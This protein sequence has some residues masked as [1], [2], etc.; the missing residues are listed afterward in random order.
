MSTKQTKISSLNELVI[1]SDHILKLEESA[2]KF[3]L[4]KPDPDD[5]YLPDKKGNF[6]LWQAEAR[7]VYSKHRKVLEMSEIVPRF[8]SRSD[9]PSSHYESFEIEIDRI[10]LKGLWFCHRGALRN[11]IVWFSPK[12][13]EKVTNVLGKLNEFI[14]K[15][16]ENSIRTPEYL[17]IRGRLMGALYY[18]KHNYSGCDDD[19]EPI[20]RPIIEAD[21]IAMI[22][23]ENREKLTLKT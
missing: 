4:G 23:P 9:E 5:K 8:F 11:R 19:G 22:Y 16:R 12:D 18:P 21:E 6:D 2:I 17:R 10:V 13:S 14:S 1:E 20:T 15:S 7:I 3:V